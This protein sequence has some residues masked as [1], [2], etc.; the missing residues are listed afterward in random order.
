MACVSALALL[1]TWV[2]GKGLGG[3]YTA[4]TYVVVMASVLLVLGGA[5][6]CR[7]AQANGGAVE[8]QGKKL[9]IFSKDTNY[10]LLYLSVAIALVVLVA[11]ALGVATVILRA[12]AVAWLL[13]MAVYYTMKLM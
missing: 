8:Y 6:L 13:I 3:V 12:V 11:A 7:K 5:I 9:R 1:G 4:L 10:A 2:S